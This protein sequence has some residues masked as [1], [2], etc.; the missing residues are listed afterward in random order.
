MDNSGYVYAGGFAGSLNTTGDGEIVVDKFVYDG[1]MSAT[2]TGFSIGASFIV[3][4]ISDIIAKYTN[5]SINADISGNL[6]E[7][8]SVFF[9]QAMNANVSSS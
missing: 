3:M 1:S 6:T 9:M 4:S 2:G 7:N 5:C 8:F